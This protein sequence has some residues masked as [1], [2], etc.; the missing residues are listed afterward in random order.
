MSAELTPTGEHVGGR[1][2]RP[3]QNSASVLKSL[4]LASTIFRSA[5][6]FGEPPGSRRIRALWAL[7]SIPQ[8][9]PPHPSLLS[10]RLRSQAPQ[11]SGPHFEPALTMALSVVSSLRMQAMSATLGSLPALVSRW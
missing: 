5:H 9:Y 4:C 7:A 3:S 2:L 1:E 6:V 11:C 8:G 10:N